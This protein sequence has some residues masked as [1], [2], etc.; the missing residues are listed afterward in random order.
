MPLTPLAGR[1]LG[2]RSTAACSEPVA[3]RLNGSVTAVGDSALLRE[4]KHLREEN[5]RLSRLLGLRGGET[6]PAP[7][8]PVSHLRRPA[9]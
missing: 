2:S 9:W 8:Q 5:A 4:L 1:P 3:P 6:Q 7:E